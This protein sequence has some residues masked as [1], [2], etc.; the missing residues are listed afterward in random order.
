MPG[1]G[2]S[3]FSIA[4]A[5]RREI[6]TLGENLPQLW[7][8]TTTTA[9]DRKQIVRLVI[10]D[11]A[12]D[13][14]R[15]RGFVWIRV[16]WQTGAAR[17]HWM[18]RTAQSYTAHADAGQIRDRI[19]ELNGMQKMDGEIAAILNDEEL[20]GMTVIPAGGEIRDIK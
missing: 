4:D 15:R 16:I 9:A 12:L 2:S 1:V 3:Q 18:Q 8:A 6:L 7:H 14:K 19:I 20:I 11:V 13:Q 17:E 5:D 10:R